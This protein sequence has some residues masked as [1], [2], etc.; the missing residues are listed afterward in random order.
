MVLKFWVGR[1]LHANLTMKDPKHQVTWLFFFFKRSN[2]NQW[3][4]W[5]TENI[6]VCRQGDK[7][8]QE[9]PNSDNTLYMEI[10]GKDHK[11]KCS[12][13]EI[14]N[15]RSL[16]LCSLLKYNSPQDALRNTL[17]MFLLIDRTKNICA[18]MLT[19][20]SSP[21]KPFLIDWHKSMVQDETKH[22]N[23]TKY[24]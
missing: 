14:Q 10:Y 11:I 8:Q 5:L 2:L 18:Q 16:M 3:I 15:F 9:H 23:V 17:C 19:H 6:S 4:C 13:L 22:S 20:P 12:G 1:S 24:C 21:P 7:W